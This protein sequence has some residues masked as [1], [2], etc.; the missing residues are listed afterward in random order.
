[1]RLFSRF[2]SLLTRFSGAC[3]LLCA[4]P[5]AHAAPFFSSDTAQA[6]LAPFVE[7]L[8]DAGGALTFDEVSGE[9]ASRFKPLVSKGVINLGY[10]KSTFWFRVPLAKGKGGIDHLLL[11]V[12]FFELGH[13]IFYAPDQKPVVTGQNYPVN[14]RPWP[15]RF[16]VFPLT[17]TDEPRYYYLQVRSDSPITVPLTLWQPS[18]FAA[19]TQQTYFAQALYYGA[20]LALLAYNL[21]IFIS[22]RE[23]IFLVYS[24][25]ACIMGLGVLAGNGFALQFLWPDQLMWNGN[26]T[27]ALYA[28]G[29]TTGIYF[30]QHFLQ[31]RALQPR[32][33]A[34]LLLIARVEILV[35]AAPWL[36]ISARIASATH[37]LLIIVGGGLAIAA[38]IRAVRSGNRSARLFLLAW[39]W[40]MLGIVVAGMR[41][42]GLLPTT[43]LT[44]YA[45]Q[46]SSF[47]EML[48]LSFALA[49]RIRMER[50]AREAAQTETLT[51]RQSLVDTLRQSEIRLEKMVAERTDEL[52]KSLQN[53]QRVLDSYIRFG[54]LIS[55]EFRNP[56]A[57]IK[58]QLTLIEK[59]R[60]HGVDQIERRLSVISGATKRLGI[61][62][63]EWLQSDRLRQ[64]TLVSNPSPIDL[65][66]WLGNIFEDCRVCY[67]NHPFELRVSTALPTL[68]ADE[69]LL[70]IALLNLVDNAAKYAP[71]GTEI[72]IEAEFANGMVTLAV[73][74]RGPG[75][76]PEH[77]V[78]IFS[79]Y[80]R[81]N[82]E[83]AAPGLGL[84]LAFVQKI[85][86][87]HHGKIELR[88]EAGKGSRFC[89]LLPCATKEQP[90]E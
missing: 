4:L 69:S 20:L 29:L 36:H 34:V 38:A 23:R 7:Y 24:L 18:A 68:V 25:F 26:I 28:L 87:M 70:R 50:D 89:I 76:P 39:G 79:A 75:I 72:T 3:Y 12:A 31:T 90:N 8:E 21:F 62:F 85:V 86:E 10:S 61:L 74:D 58:S 56:L 15:H 5:L 47:A 22:L 44:A 42:F 88:S 11:E 17:L 9:A 73:T 81:S 32:L 45:V 77:Q 57:I 37:S 54:S 46:L 64:Q 60:Q 53:E 14:S 84:G 19:D 27:I 80:F 67:T 13:V 78:E 83:Q 48:L 41:N 49:E 65:K 51:A 1:M 66:S 30:S 40:L 43:T 33:H 52:R 55:H 63:E 59:E 16:Y 2:F 6:N 71:V 35:A 82:S